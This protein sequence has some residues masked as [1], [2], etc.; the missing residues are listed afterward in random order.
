MG[1][2]RRLSPRL[3]RESAYT[4]FPILAVSGFE[5]PSQQQVLLLASRAVVVA[6][7]NPCCSTFRRCSA[8]P[9]PNTTAPHNSIHKIFAT[10]QARARTRE[11]EP[12]LQGQGRAR[13]PVPVDGAVPQRGARRRPPQ[14]PR[15]RPARRAVRVLQQREG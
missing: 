10:T 9:R 14:R 5:I 2:L 1:A 3:P 6:I 7:R 15:P 12:G 4:H 13:R 8:T 11:A